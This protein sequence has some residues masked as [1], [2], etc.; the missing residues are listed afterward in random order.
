MYRCNRAPFDQAKLGNE[1]GNM[2]YNV[3]TLPLPSTNLH[4]R[5]AAFPL[6]AVIS[7]PLGLD[8]YA[9]ALTTAVCDVV[10]ADFFRD[11]GLG[12]IQYLPYL[13]IVNVCAFIFVGFKWPP[14]AFATIWINWY[15][16]QITSL[17]L[18]ELVVANSKAKRSECYTW[19]SALFACLG[20]CILRGSWYFAVP[21]MILLG[22]IVWR[23]TGAWSKK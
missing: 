17:L 23:W 6:I 8:I 2:T 7:F 4:L 16:F 13:I 3:Q 15:A 20:L 1:I 10:I 9:I 11:Q 19:F 12:T 5:I 14:T 21:A 22:G 18:A